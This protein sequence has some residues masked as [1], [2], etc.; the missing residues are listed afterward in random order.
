[1][2]QQYTDRITVL[3]FIL[4]RSSQVPFPRPISCRQIRLY[5][6][7]CQKQLKVSCGGH[8]CR[9]VADGSFR[10]FV[11]TVLPYLCHERE[12][13]VLEI[14]FAGFRQNGENTLHKMSPDANKELFSA[15][16][17]PGCVRTLNWGW[18]NLT[19]RACTFAELIWKRCVF[20]LVSSHAFFMLLC[21]VRH[22]VPYWFCF[23]HCRISFCL[24]FYLLCCTVFFCLLLFDVALCCCD[25]ICSTSFCHLVF[26]HALLRFVALC[27][28]AWHSCSE[29]CIVLFHCAAMRFALL[30]R[31]PGRVVLILP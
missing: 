17:G 29:Y 1:M 13:T 5:T 16:I 14:S 15:K 27:I 20:C 22:F 9:T 11:E 7:T 30:F 3:N 31:V 25:V 21:Y 23:I 19:F 2:D 6:T 4:N 26:C 12:L 28:V 8:C 18:R 10:G 24:L